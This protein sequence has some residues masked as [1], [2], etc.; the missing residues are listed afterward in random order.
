MDRILNKIIGDRIKA[1]RTEKGLKQADLAKEIDSTPALIS[2]IENGGQA[3]QL[4]DLYKIAEL[5][6]KEVSHFLPSHKEVKAAVPSIDKEKEKLSP[7][8]VA[9]VEELRKQISKEE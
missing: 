4:G 9:V 2:N 5:L 1:A 3:I 7:R 8:E 6:N